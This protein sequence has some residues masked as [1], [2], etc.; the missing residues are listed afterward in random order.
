M[1]QSL[2]SYSYFKTG[3]VCSELYIPSKEQQVCSIMKSLSQ[4]SVAHFILGAGT[5][6]LVSDEPWDG[7]VLILSELRQLSAKGKRLRVG[8]GVDNTEVSK[9]AASLSLKGAEFMNRLPGQI[10][11]TV[12]MNARCYGGEMSQIVDKVRTVSPSG[13]Q[14]EWLGK[15]VFRGYKDTNFMTN[16][17]VVVGCDI[18][19]EVGDPQEIEAKMLH[20][21]ND[22]VQKHQFDFPSCG[23]VFKNDYSVG[24]PSGVLLDQV[25]VKKFSVGGAVV[26]PFHANF[27]FNKGASSKQVLELSLRMREAV[28]NKF[29]AWLEYEM[30]VLGQIPEDL[31][32]MIKEKRPHQLQ[33]SLLADLRAKWVTK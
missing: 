3:G 27:I 24:V 26:S 22:R 1:S 2:R 10:G 30:E 18:A 7:A 20:C 16:G 32:P 31:A 21:E 8:A 5:N 17:H 25:G 13:E 4:R 9:F 33:D 12:R 6:S 11:G 28:W 19:L 23:C 15:D 29:G 14:H